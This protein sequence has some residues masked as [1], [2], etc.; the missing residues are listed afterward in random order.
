MYLC[1]S[2][3]ASAPPS[4]EESCRSDPDPGS[5]SQDSAVP[6]TESTETKEETEPGHA[7]SQE[8][9]ESPAAAKQE[10]TGSSKSDKHPLWVVRLLLAVF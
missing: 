7:G 1:P 3:A 10:R 9:G 8:S 6:E 2:P 5:A 4:A